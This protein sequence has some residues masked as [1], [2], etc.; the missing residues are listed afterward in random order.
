MPR[1]PGRAV[2]GQGGVTRPPMRSLSPSPGPRPAA[3]GPIRGR[4]RFFPARE[5]EAPEEHEADR[6]RSERPAP[7]SARR[8]HRGRPAR[9]RR[10]SRVPRS[11][12]ASEPQNHPGLA[13]LQ[14]HRAA[15]GRHHPNGR[16]VFFID[17]F[18]P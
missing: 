15:R 14:R 13:E 16:G 7:R 12:R 8:T 9:C 18:C 10:S 1:V 5:L 11:L 4:D 2:V 17:S 6:E 3:S